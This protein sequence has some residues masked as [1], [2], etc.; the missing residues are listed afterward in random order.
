[1]ARYFVAKFTNEAYDVAKRGDSMAGIDETFFK[2]HERQF[3]TTETGKK[4]LPLAALSPIHNLMQ[5]ASGLQGDL[6]RLEVPEAHRH[7]IGTAASYM[8]D[9]Q[10][11]TLHPKELQLSFVAIKSFAILDAHP[12]ANKY[13]LFDF[14]GIHLVNGTPREF[15]Y[16]V[17][18]DRPTLSLAFENAEFLSDVPL[19]EENP[20]IPSDFLAIPVYSLRLD[21]A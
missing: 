19:A 6:R 3:D 16:G 13:D 17:V 7:E 8:L 2:A 14:H 12:N 21:A 10:L 11:Q 5:Y 20:N 15:I 18:Y 1:M 4:P 9:K